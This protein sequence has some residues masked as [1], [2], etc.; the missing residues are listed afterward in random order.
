FEGKEVVGTKKEFAI[1]LAVN[2]AIGVLLYFLLGNIKQTLAGTI[3]LALVIGTL[4][5]WRFRVAIAFIG[6]VLLLLTGTIDLKHTIEF[7]SLDVI[8]FLV[9]MMI[10]VGILRRSGF[11]RWLLA[12][13]LQLSRFEPNRLMLVIL[14]LSALMAAMV[15]EV[16]SI[17]FVTALVLDLCDFFKVKPVNYVIS[18]VLATN[19]G[20][21]WTV[22]G[23]PIGILIALRSGLTFENFL[24]TALP[25]GLVSLVS[26]M[27]IILV[28]Q[29][30]D[31]RQL[32][33]KVEA[34]SP[35]ERA[36]FLEELTAGRDRRL[37]N[38]SAAIFIGVI[39][40]LALH[41]RLELMLE[42]EH[43]ILLVATSITGAGIVMLWQRPIARELLMRDVD[44]WTLVFFMFL[45]AKA[46]CL[47]YVGLTEVISDSLTALTGGGAALL[48]VLIL[49]ISG[50]TS[51]V[52]DNVVVVAAFVPVLQDL[53]LQVGSMVLWWAL[54][55][56]GCYGGNMTMVGST[57]NIVALGILEDRKS[58]HMTL[59]Y[60]IKIGLWGSL[61]PMTIGTLA[62][63]I[64]S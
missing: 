14:F 58:I 27:V 22:L 9:G 19:I 18:V 10:I 20:S 6:I 30:G 53:S 11:F 45:F 2:I 3:F 47:K 26:L 46:G 34:A 42:L 64:I 54:L 50:L 55:F 28:W 62:L 24:Q 25:I 59:S 36:R 56:G 31:L 13:G 49:W 29:R 39:F 40:F 51:A 32:K 38:G 7:M 12:R 8:L 63:L 15:D 16:T 35:E 33:A 37:F 48:I 52:M 57:A 23:N 41:Y 21:S 44:W 60:W 43:N 1:Y 17:L 61:V 4:M 5:F